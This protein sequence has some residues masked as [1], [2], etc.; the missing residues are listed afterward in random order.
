[1]ES[2]IALSPAGTTSIEVVDCAYPTPG[3]SMTT[4][5]ILPLSMT[6]LKDAPVP[7][8]FTTKVGTE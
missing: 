5:L 7:S 8:P 3:F 4:L 6:A 1:M 2:K